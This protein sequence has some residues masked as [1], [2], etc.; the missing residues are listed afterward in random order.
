MINQIVIIIP[1]NISDR[2]GP[3]ELINKKL[4]KNINQFA[5][6]ECVK[7]KI[8]FEG[9][10]DIIFGFYPTICVHR[11]GIPQKNL[12]A[13]QIMFQLNPHPNWVINARLFNEKHKM[14]NQFG[15]WTNEPKFPFFS[16]FFDKRLDF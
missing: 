14:K 10:G 9:N 16:Y 12:S 2:H 3:L 5:N 15:I 8:N 7:D 1:I 13:T 11:D 4:S 6:I